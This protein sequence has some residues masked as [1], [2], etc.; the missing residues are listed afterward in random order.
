LNIKHHTTNKPSKND[1]EEKNT[2]CFG[3]GFGNNNNIVVLD[4][5]EGDKKASL[6]FFGDKYI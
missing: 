1:E 4:S 2:L 3:F 5:F 6:R